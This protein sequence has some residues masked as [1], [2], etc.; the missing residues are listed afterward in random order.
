MTA[1]GA[2]TGR[3]AGDEAS[4]PN[5]PRGT[6]L[7]EARGVGKVFGGG[8]L[9]KR[10]TVAL[11]D[12][13]FGIETDPP[14]ITAIVGESGSGKTTLARLLLGL[15]APTTGSVLYNG[16]K[17]LKSP[18]NYPAVAEAYS[19]ASGDFNRDGIRAF[20]V[21]DYSNSKTAIV[22]SK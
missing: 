11:E 20:A 22:L 1:H 17:G 12:F 9:S 5:V 4:R 2:T 19:V 3:M 10:Q 21:P 16:K 7:L 8:M 14:S 18:K 13:T 6:P 15:V